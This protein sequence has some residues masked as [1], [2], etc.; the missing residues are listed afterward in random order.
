M[1]NCLLSLFSILLTYCSINAVSIIPVEPTPE[2]NHVNIRIAYPQDLSYGKANP[3]MVQVRLEGFALGTNSSFPRARQIANSDRGQSMHVIIDNKPYFPVTNTGIDP[4]DEV[5]DYF[6]E[7]Y[8][9]AIPF[10]LEEGVHTLRIY[11]ARSFGESLKNT[12]NFDYIYF[13]VGKKTDENK[14]VNLD[15]PLLTYNEPSMRF[16]YEV[17]QPILLDFFISNCELSKDGYKVK[18]VIDGTTEETLT[19]WQPYY[20]YG[21]K[22]GTHKINLILLDPLDEE[23]GGNY[24]SIERTFIVH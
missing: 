24:N 22:R 16:F 2:P 11:C 6:V 10:D 9:F 19:N 17:G 15:G 5:G 3:V 4:F 23:V 12:S 8:K 1:N 7:S 21:L 13:F 14:G 20:I 18:V